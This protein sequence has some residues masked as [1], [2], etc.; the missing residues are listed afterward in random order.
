MKELSNIFAGKNREQIIEMV[1][2]A[3]T[4]GLTVEDYLK[5][6]DAKRVTDALHSFLC[7]ATHDG[8]HRICKWYDEEASETPMHG[9][10]HQYWLALAVRISG[11]D[12]TMLRQTISKAAKAVSAMNE[13]EDN[14][15]GCLVIAIFSKDASKLDHCVSA[16]HLTS[17]TPDTLSDFGG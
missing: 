1:E 10:D 16:E 14:L 11:G 8:E 17:S 6:L 4:M 7:V 3:T 15:F 5:D 2:A 12:Y 9:K 13:D